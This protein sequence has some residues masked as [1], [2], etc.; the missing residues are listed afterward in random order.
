MKSRLLMLVAGIMCFNFFGFSSDKTDKFF[1]PD[2]LKPWQKWVLYNHKTID[3][4]QIY[5]TANSCQCVWP[6]QLSIDVKEKEAEFE[7]KV[8]IFA[9]DYV[10]IPGDSVFWPCEV[11]VNGKQTAVL[12]RNNAPNIEL[13]AG[14]YKING[15]I[16]WDNRPNTLK[17]PEGTAL[18][19][20]QSGSK[21]VSKANIDKNGMLWLKEENE[22]T[23]SDSLV[24]DNVE[25]R[26]Y[27]KVVDAIPLYIITMA[28]LIVSGH[29]RE[30]VLGKFLPDG[31]IP[32]YLHSE[33]P[34]RIDTDGNVK[35]QVKNG[36]WIIEMK[37][38]L[39]NNKGVLKMEQKTRD[40]PSQEIWALQADPHLRSISIKGAQAIDP[41][42]TGIPEEWKQLPVFLVT[43]DNSFEI[44]EE[45]RGDYSPDPN[46]LIIDRTLWLDF[47]GSGFTV[48]DKINGTVSRPGRLSMDQGYTLGSVVLNGIPQMVTTVGEN[49]PGVEYSQGELQL[50]CVS[51]SKGT[52]MSAGGWNQAFANVCSTLHIPPGWSVFYINGTDY[53]NNTWISR[54]TV[55]DIFLLLVLV[56][57]IYRIYNLKWS[58]IAAGA[59]LLTFHEKGVPLFLWLNLIAG[60]ALVK[61]IPK[62]KVKKIIA[63]YTV[64]SFLAVAGICLGF[65][66]TQVRQALYP[67]LEM[68]NSAVDMGVS[69]M[70]NKAE[71]SSIPRKSL[72]SKYVTNQAA[73]QNLEEYDP[74]AIIQTGP[75]EPLWKWN[76]VTF[77][78]S[79][80][81][82]RDQKIKL[83]LIS[84]IVNRIMNI[85]R[86][87]MILLL[88][89][90]LG[91]IISKVDMI[92]LFT[93]R[94]LKKSGIIGLFIVW[95]IICPS[96]A[97]AEIPSQTI[98]NEL[99]KRL[100]E[101][102]GTCGIEC[103][104]VQQGSIGIK[105]EKVTIKLSIDAS[106]TSSILLPGNRTSWFAEK[107]S[108]NDDEEPALRSTYEGGLLIVVPG[109]HNNVELTGNLTGNKGEIHFPFPVNNMTVDADKWIVSG[110]ANGKIPGGV[111]RIDKKEMSASAER[112]QQSKTLNS[113]QALPFVEVTRSINL[114]KE[115]GITTTVRRISPE[116]EP[117]C[118]SIPLLQ[119]ESIISSAVSDPVGFITVYLKRDQQEFSWQST[120][121]ITPEINL[122]VPSQD[123]WVEVWNLNHSPRWHIETSGL[124]QVKKDAGAIQSSQVWCPLTGE[125]VVIKI[126]KPQAVEGHTMTLSEVNLNYNPGIKASENRLKVS[127]LSSQADLIRF[128]LPQNSVLDG[129]NIDGISQIVTYNNSSLSVPVHPGTQ[130]LN[131][132]W[133]TRDTLKLLTK[134]PLVDCGMSSSNT[135]IECMVPNDRWILFAGGP[136][137][138][139]ALL[140]WAMLIVLLIIAIIL[141]KI[142]SLPLR[143][144]HW[145]LLSAGMSTIDNIGGIFVVL[146][147]FAFSI[148]AKV[149]NKNKYFN[150]AQIGCILLTVAAM[151]SLIATI[152]LGLL[153]TPDMQ[154][155]G[156]DSS[157]HFLRW[158]QDLSSQ[159]L[160]QGWFISFP[161][162]VY[163]LL[164][165]LWSLWLALCL[166]KW[167]KWGWKSF[168]SG[169][170]WKTKI[171]KII[172]TSEA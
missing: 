69:D 91:M 109:G 131:I 138:G 90:G 68:K 10:I 102:T 165:L 100:T 106:E 135:T 44:Y 93:K 98:L 48:K 59:F 46:N 94:L 113:D 29:D 6:S 171:K 170:L 107:V 16:K 21:K 65:A 72:V 64:I 161:I 35:A 153:S 3:C 146:W 97:K 110:I 38:R 155:S 145:F 114:D 86:V 19:D 81:V 43:K 7:F 122:E 163:R 119:T 13:S 169:G 83:I 105:D 172:N 150:Y 58:L 148:R 82:E 2:E 115:W 70:K 127:V 108:V 123:K 28:K 9:D 62:T 101:K 121:K 76:Q 158:F 37:S 128:K 88:L 26:V 24:A 80:P 18:V 162:W 22:S 15:V 50:E 77:G 63:V 140:F 45:Q 151:S 104:S 99:E 152:P 23:G 4:P 25:V 78:W 116:S 142:K 103:I 160:P 57:S 111:I 143:W 164:M 14:T 53:V 30:L 85:V 61:V 132:K 137:M 156:N 95:G 129:V 96:P 39:L 33:I 74:N 130:I 54:W 36:T 41:G 154:I 47:N 34:S 133:K 66:L 5:G 79:G 125:K 32:V 117:L 12:R 42:Q 139:P 84:P 71:N 147:F 168:S 159:T 167:V 52:E 126:Q 120:L 92:H 51:R 55:W 149:T 112:S 144:Y 49:I 8:Q 31:A 118:V 56:V 134:T 27:R 89:F 166:T 40:W 1:M 124:S 87:C 157:S 60:I 73:L 67:Q 75:G 11:T 136:M 141:G 17:I 20:I